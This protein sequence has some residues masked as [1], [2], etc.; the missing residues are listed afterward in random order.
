MAKNEKLKE[1]YDVLAEL[2]DLLTDRIAE[3]NKMKAGNVPAFTEQANHAFMLYRAKC[4]KAFYIL[5]D[6]L[7][8]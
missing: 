1:A 3:N 7:G 8:E 2:Q 4:W 6:F 5:R